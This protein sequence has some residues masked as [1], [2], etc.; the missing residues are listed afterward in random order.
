QQAVNASDYAI[1]QFA[2][3]RK[4]LLV[5]GRWNYRRSS[6]VVCYLFY[7]SVMFACPLIFYAFVNGFRFDQSKPT[8]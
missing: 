2:Y 8:N 3:L 7:K 6:R 5:H 1:A 4:L